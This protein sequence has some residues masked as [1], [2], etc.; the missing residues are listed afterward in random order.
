MPLINKKGKIMGKVELP[1]L[2]KTTKTG[3]IQTCIISHLNETFTV[4]FGQ[5]D[6]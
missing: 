2:Y 4:E 6:G 3:A 5:L 1:Q